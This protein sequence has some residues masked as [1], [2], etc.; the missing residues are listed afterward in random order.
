MEQIN[1]IELQGHVGNVRVNI[2]GDSKVVNFTLA[3]NHLYSGKD[4]AAVSE[5]TWFNVVAWLN[6][7]MPD[8]DK[9]V[10]GTPVNVSGRIRST[11]YTSADGIERI[12]YEVI[13]QKIRLL[14][15]VKNQE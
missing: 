2:V 7:D 12:S 6:K 13:A 10:K 14:K 15:E 8:F 11:R 5:T 9:I 3:T 4:G 1:R